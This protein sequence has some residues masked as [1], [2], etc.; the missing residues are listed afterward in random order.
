MKFEAPVKINPI[1]LINL[2]FNQHPT[3]NSQMTEND[4]EHWVLGFY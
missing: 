4:F 3:S 1:D 2:I